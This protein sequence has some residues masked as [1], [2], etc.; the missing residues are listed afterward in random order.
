MGYLFLYLIITVVGY[1]I[2]S[3]M[4]R[5]SIRLSWV[6]PVQTITIIVLV[7]LMGSRIGANDDTH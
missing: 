4:K 7:F 6:G 3:R 1:L 5:R 2:G